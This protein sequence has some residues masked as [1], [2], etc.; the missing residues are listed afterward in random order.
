M[1]ESGKRYT[2]KEITDAYPNS[3]VLITDIEDDDNGEMK[4]V[5]FL[6]VASGD[7]EKKVMDLDAKGID[8]FIFWTG[9]YEPFSGFIFL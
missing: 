2:W 3:N 9:E 1:L 8:Y 5:T 6:D 4:Y 7:I